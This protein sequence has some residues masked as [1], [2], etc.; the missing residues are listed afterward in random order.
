[1]LRTLIARL[2]WLG[3][4]TSALFGLV[5]L[6][7]VALGLGTAALAAVPGDPLKLGQVNTINALTSLTGR[8]G[9][10]LLKLDN[11]G[12]GPALAVQVEPGKPPLTV[13]A[14]AAKA[15]NLNADKLDGLDAGGFAPRL[16][17]KVRFDGTLLHGNGATSARREPVG[18]GFQYFVVFDR[19]VAACGYVATVGEDFAAYDPP[20]EIQ[21]ALAT[22]PS[23]TDTVFV[24][25]DAGTTTVARQ[26]SLMVLC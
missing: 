3:R 15:T 9:T 11:N 14:G 26:F 21:A 24:S 23:Q 4:L 7:G 20:G 17:A 1:M 25:I 2:L 16:W 18:A 5:L 6:L 19:S 13:N 12:A 10:A 8:S 22:L